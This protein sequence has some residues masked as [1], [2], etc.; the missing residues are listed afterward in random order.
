MAVCVNEYNTNLEKT[1]DIVRYCQENELPFVGKIP[2]DPKV[3]ETVNQGLSIVDVKCSAG[4]A[5]K[6]IFRQTMQVLSALSGMIT[7]RA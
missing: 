1:A 4:E 5:V 2:F 6:A 7:F 3:V